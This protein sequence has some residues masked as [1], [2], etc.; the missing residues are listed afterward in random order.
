MLKSAPDGELPS[1][2][3]VT[4]AEIDE[5]KRGS[6]EGVQEFSVAQIAKLQAA[7]RL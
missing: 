1:G 4:T 2:A 7:N 6:E 5:R 3:L